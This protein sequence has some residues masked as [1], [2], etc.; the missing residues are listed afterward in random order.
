MEM[1][2]PPFRDIIEHS[3]TSVV[4]T[5]KGLVQYANPAFSKLIGREIADIIGLTA[6]ELVDPEDL[7]RIEDYRSRRTA[8][9]SVPEDYEARLLAQSGK[10]I[11]VRVMPHVV[12]HKGDKLIISNIT[13]ISKRVDAAQELEQTQSKLRS[14]LDGSLQ[15]VMITRKNKF[16]FVNG[17][18]ADMMGYS[19]DEVMKRTPRELIHPADHGLLDRMGDGGLMGREG[20]PRRHSIRAVQPDGSILWMEVFAKK[21]IWNG[22]PAWQF[23]VL[24]ISSLKQTEEKLIRAR[25]EAEAANRA[26]SSFLANISH[27]LRTPLNAIIGFSQLLETTILNDERQMEYGKYIHQSGSHLLQIINNLLDLSKAEAEAFDLHDS[28]VD[29]QE[30]TAAA[31]LIVAG[32]TPLKKGLID[33]RVSKGDHKIRV[34]EGILQQVL[35]NLVSNAVK[36]T[37]T[38]GEIVV[39]AESVDDGS[40]DILVRDTGIGIAEEDIEKV[41]TPFGQ[42]HSDLARAFEGAGLGLPLCKN[43]IE[44]H[45]GSLRIESRL[46]HGT[47]VIVRLPAERVGVV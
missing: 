22:L 8:G 17:A 43:L 45:D 4:V 36:F 13:D 31:I 21:T 16:Q 6:T 24:D 9:E 7:R 40:L 5:C 18:F 28:V 10:R 33:C 37:D 35:I 19:I 29:L 41:M 2:E 27:E 1:I 23:N 46:G 15:G 25:D 30:V 44:Q 34:D 14:L 12:V 38:D 39:S 20:A 47:T 26:K 3:P 32:A 11:W 42:V